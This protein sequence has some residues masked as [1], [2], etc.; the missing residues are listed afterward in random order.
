M[1]NKKQK[2]NNNISINNVDII[3]VKI[4]KNSVVGTS[5]ICYINQNTVN[6]LRT[7]SLPFIIL[8]EDSVHKLMIKTILHNNDLKIIFFMNF[9][10]QMIMNT[11]NKVTWVLCTS[12]NT[13]S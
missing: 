6:I 10:I 3:N 4:D 12:K 11:N 13:I 9:N 8:N 1:S 5:D 2:F 7:N